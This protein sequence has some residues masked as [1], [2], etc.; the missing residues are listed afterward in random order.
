MEARRADG[1]LQVR[2]AGGGGGRARLEWIPPLGV[3]RQP[4]AL[5]SPS[6]PAG[7]RCPRMPFNLDMHAAPPYS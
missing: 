4:R 5:R 1:S 7:A 2:R 3:S 6:P